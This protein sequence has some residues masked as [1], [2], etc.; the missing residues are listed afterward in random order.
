MQASQ[1]AKGEVLPWESASAIEV[2]L[3]NELISCRIA[4]SM[5]AIRRGHIV[6]TPTE[7]NDVERANVVSM[8]LRWLINSK[9]QEFYPEVELGLNH[10]F[11]K[12][13]MVHY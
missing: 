11:E 1:S 5:K 2:R 3:C 12:G 4:M 9:M 10:L 13:M 7:S 6:A 8:F